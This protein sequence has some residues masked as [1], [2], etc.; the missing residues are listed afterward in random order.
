MDLSYHGTQGDK[1]SAPLYITTK[2]YVASKH[3][4]N[5]SHEMQKLEL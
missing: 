4:E 2:Q 5:V 1:I 3:E